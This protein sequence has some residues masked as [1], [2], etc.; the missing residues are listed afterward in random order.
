M[1]PTHIIP[2]VHAEKRK[3]V[4]SKKKKKGKGGKGDGRGEGKGGLR[5]MSEDDR[6]MERDM[7]SGV[8]ACGALHWVAA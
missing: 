8:L 7:C 2:E 4:K 3:G 5:S 6:I 1:S